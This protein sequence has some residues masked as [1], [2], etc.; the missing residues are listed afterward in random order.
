MAMY[1]TLWEHL[2]EIGRLA[3]EMLEKLTREMAKAQG[4][5]EDLKATDQMLWVQRMNNIRNAAEEIILSEL[6]YS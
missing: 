2:N 3:N 6:V 5:T 1:D 4:V